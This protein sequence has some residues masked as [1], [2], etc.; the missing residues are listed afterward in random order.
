MI[1]A[2]LA[3]ATS[4]LFGCSD[5]LG[6]IASR[7]D[8]AVRVTAAAHVLGV[9]AFGALVWIV[10]AEKV[11]SSDL[12]FGALAGL[13]AAI[14]VGS[15]Y[16]ALARGRMS[17]V[18]P[19][20]AALSGSLPAI[21]DLVRGSEVGP[22]SAVALVLAIAA[23]IVVSANSHADERAAMPVSAVAFAVMAGV[24][25]AGS[26]LS[27]SFT[28]AESALWPLLVSRVVSATA[29]IAIVVL[30]GLGPRMEPTAVRPTLGAG[31]LEVAA[32]V[33]MINAIRIGPLAIASVL[34]SLYPV[35]VVVLARA[36]LGERLTGLQKAAVVVALAAVL[37][38]AMP[39]P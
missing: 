4:F 34:G 15:L 30:T 36:L 24:G 32:N 10:P 29:M 33:T 23:V 26:F 38:A 16:T 12:L 20:T 6:G 14:G 2:L 37:L 22:F 19:V 21:Y 18:A 31:M 11:T 17:I 7:R 5:F 28:A 13:G 8:E 9:V 27:L 25:F 35:V 39:A 3:T 1:T